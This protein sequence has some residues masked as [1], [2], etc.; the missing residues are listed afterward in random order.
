MS[1]GMNG[2]SNAADWYNQSTV[3]RRGKQ[4]EISQSGPGESGTYSRGME[5][6]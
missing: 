6:H 1:E 5:T 3:E 4:L 2:K